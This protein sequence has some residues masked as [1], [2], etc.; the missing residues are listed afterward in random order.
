M[1]DPKEIK[2]GLALCGAQAG[3]CRKC[4]YEEGCLWHE[5]SREL[6]NDALKY[7]ETLEGVIKADPRY[8]GYDLLTLVRDTCEG[9]LHCSE[10]PLSDADGDCPFIAKDGGRLLPSEWEIG[11]MCGR[12]P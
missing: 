2:T 10:C 3:D 4:P 11:R 7:I 1:R 9:Y 8:F 5:G 12:E 6:S